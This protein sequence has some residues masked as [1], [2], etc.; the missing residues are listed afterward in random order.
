MASPETPRVA[1]YI[2]A[3]I[4]TS[5]LS[6]SLSPALSPSSVLSR[7]R[8]ITTTSSQNVCGGARQTSSSPVC[9]SHLHQPMGG[10][11]LGSPSL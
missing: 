7:G 8:G 10:E 6:A 3:A 11:P 4:H 1:S 5:A 2:I 9:L